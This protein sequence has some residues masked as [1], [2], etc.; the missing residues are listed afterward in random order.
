MKFFIPHCFFLVSCITTQ[1]QNLTD[2]AIRLYCTGRIAYPKA[3]DN[4]NI[5]GTVALIFDTDSLGHINNIRVEKSVGYGCDEAAINAL[6]TCKCNPLP[7]ERRYLPQY[8][9]HIAFAFTRNDD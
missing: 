5:T 9:Q 3:A 2:T 6:K 7:V 8:N 1:A 4:N